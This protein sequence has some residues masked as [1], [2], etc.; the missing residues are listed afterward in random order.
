M[1]KQTLHRQAFDRPPGSIA[2][3]LTTHCNLA[4]KMCSVWKRREE[5]LA[6]DKI[7]SLMDEARA[8]GATGFS[9]AGAEPF[10]REDTAEILAYA[11]RI[12]FQ[13]ICVV[14]NGVLL[15]NGQRLATLEKLRNLNLVI[16]LD[17]PR[18][19]HDDLRGKGVYDGAVEA[20][21]EIR[22]RGITC[23]ISSVIMRQ[24]IDHLKE[25]VDL[26]VD[27]AIPVISMQPYNRETAGMDN[28]HA[29]FE[30]S[31]KEEKPLRKM[32]ENLLRYAKSKNVKIYTANMLD[33]VPPYLT[34]RIRPIPPDG[35][36]VPSKFLLVDISGE[37]YPCFMMRIRM[38]ENSMGNVHENSLDKIWHNNIHRD[39]T[40]MGLNRKC[41]RCFAAC[42]DVEGYNASA[43][44]SRVASLIRYAV[45]RFI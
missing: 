41:P 37:T 1:D 16:S 26:A 8:L 11:E 13:E 5:E 29:A 27:L 20:L 32:L 22:E 7:L 21:R 42:S 25:I 44:R 35:C 18:E 45:K 40:L 43:K 9:T 33:R 2:I 10:M 12:G 28:N 4:C 23:S 30:F 14:S 34:R 19:V 3:E 6:H 39:L 15:N 31:L 38:K 24:T 17:G 36:F